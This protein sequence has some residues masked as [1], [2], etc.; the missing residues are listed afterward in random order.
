MKPSIAI[1]ILVE[2]VITEQESV[3]TRETW[4]QS[5][6]SVQF[7]NQGGTP[8]NSRLVELDSGVR[9]HF[10]QDIKCQKL[11]VFEIEHD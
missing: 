8:S 5:V 1:F 3:S 10:E 2:I 7:K 9:Q 4:S 6:R 11:L